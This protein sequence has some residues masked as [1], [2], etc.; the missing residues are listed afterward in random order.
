MLREANQE[1]DPELEELAMSVRG[2]GQKKKNFRAPGGGFRVNH[3]DAGGYRAG[4]R[5]DF[6]RSSYDDDDYADRRPRRRFDDDYSPQ[7]RSRS[8][9]DYDY[10]SR[11]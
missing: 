3:R 6:R 9:D 10:E 8:Y 4:A 1:V 11:R 5:R 2:S 7:R